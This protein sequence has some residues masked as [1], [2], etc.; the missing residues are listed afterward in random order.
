MDQQAV[1]RLKEELSKL[2]LWLAKDAQIRKYFCVA[3]ENASEDYTRTM[4][5]STGLAD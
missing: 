2:M 1:T 5:A 4:Q 3:Y